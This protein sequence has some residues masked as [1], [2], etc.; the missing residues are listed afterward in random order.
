MDRDVCFWIG[1]ADFI[2][3]C[4]C[5]YSKE[6]RPKSTW[7]EKKGSFFKEIPL[8]DSKPAASGRIV[9]VS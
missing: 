9:S 3:T 1:G 5:D 2:C 6:E 4:R 8:A 7:G